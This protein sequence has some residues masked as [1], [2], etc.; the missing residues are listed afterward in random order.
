[1]KKLLA[2]IFAI[3]CLA[4]C[5]AKPND[6]STTEI[7]EQPAVEE[8]AKQEP[9]QQVEEVPMQAPPAETAVEEPAAELT[10]DAPEETNDTYTMAVEL[11]EGLVDDAIGFSLSC[12]NFKGFPAAEPVNE[13]Y[14]ELVA[15]LET[16]TRETIHSQCLERHCMANVYGTVLSTALTSDFL[17]IQVEYEYRVEY[18]DSDEPVINTRTDYFN[19]QTG[20][21]RT[22]TE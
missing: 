22:E 4:G 2:A 21:V 12:P 1:M 8:P 5:S 3:F 15:H 10:E 14:E 9:A 19:I 13:F 7:L 11:V 18:S 6:S 20:E 16:H 17:E